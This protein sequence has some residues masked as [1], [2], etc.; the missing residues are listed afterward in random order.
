MRPSSGLPW[1]VPGTGDR[2]WSATSGRVDW[3]LVAVCDLD[4]ARA[5]KV[6]GARSTVEVETSLERGAGPR[7]H[8]RG[9]DRHAGADP[10]A[11][12]PGGAARPASTCWSRSRWPT[13]PEAAGPDGRG[14]RGRRP[15]ADVRP[16]LL[17]H[18]GGAVHPRARRRRAR[19]ATSSTSTRCGS[20][21]ASIQPDVD[22]FWDLA[23]HDL[24]ILDYVLPGGL[25]P[26]R[27]RRARVP[28]RSGRA[29][30][31]SATSPC[32]CPAARIA[33]VHVNWL[34]PTKIRQMVI[35]GTRRTA[36]LGR[37]EP[38]AAASRL[39]PRRR[40]ARLG[41]R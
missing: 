9:R 23:P 41:S 24:S 25:R 5:R 1:S 13:A 19:S 17:L 33:H 22:V 7:R 16:H 36:G 18:P 10:R 12:R 38:A 39:R 4:E 40:P 15:G 35:G 27:R 8:R 31:A 2:T 28:I 14:G 26:D 37:P 11:D 30:P 3:D 6:I 32:R 29:R 21:S 34:S 20:T